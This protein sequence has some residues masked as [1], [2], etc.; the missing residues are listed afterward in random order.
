MR[1]LSVACLCQPLPRT[2]V[3]PVGLHRI[4]LQL[5]L[6]NTQLSPPILSNCLPLRRAIFLGVQK[7]RSLFPPASLASKRDVPN[8]RPPGD[9]CSAR[10][11]TRLQQTVRTLSA[12][13]LLCPGHPFVG[14]LSPG[15]LPSSRPRHVNPVCPA[16]KHSIPYVLPLRNPDKSDQMHRW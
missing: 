15:P 12:H 16:W 2:P 9:S 11:Y 6:D 13:P 14:R 1:L 8:A 5:I 7:N 10:E 3:T 4:G